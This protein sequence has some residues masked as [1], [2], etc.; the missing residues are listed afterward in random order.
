MGQQIT[1]LCS[2]AEDGGWGSI[3]ARADLQVKAGGFSQANFIGDARS[4]E[5]AALY[6]VQTKILGEGAFGSVRRAVHR[7]SGVVRAVKN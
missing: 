1:Q 5:I 6:D 2:P 4:L 7:S 3:Q